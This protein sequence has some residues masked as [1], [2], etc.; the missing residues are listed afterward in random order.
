MLV[1]KDPVVVEP[2]H[3]VKQKVLI[4]V[5][6]KDPAK[7]VPRCGFPLWRMMTL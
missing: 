4:P 5:A 6:I 7:K 1:K 3:V 2:Q